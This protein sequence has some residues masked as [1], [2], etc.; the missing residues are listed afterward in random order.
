MGPNDQNPAWSPDG[1]QL[2]FQSDRSGQGDWD[3]YLVRWDGSGLTQLTSGPDT[4]QDPTWSPDGS[5][6][7]FVRNGLIHVMNVD[8]SGVTQLT[9]VGFDT[10]PA[11]SPNGTRI[12]FEHN[13]I[14]VVNADGSGVVQLTT[15]SSRLTD[16]QP[17]WSPDGSRIVFQR[18]LDGW[19]W[20]YFM[21]QDGTGL[22]RVVSGSSPAWSPD[23][24][25]IVYHSWG[26]IVVM[27]DGTGM[28]RLGLTG[29]GY[30]PAWS[31][32]GTMPPEPV[33]FRSVEMAGGDGQTGTVGTTLTL[34]FSVR[35]VGDDGTPQAGARIQWQV[36]WSGTTD[37]AR[38]DALSVENGIT[39]ANGISSARLTLDGPSGLVHVRAA[40][41]DGTTRRGEVVFT[42]TAVP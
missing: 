37:P 35:V 34:P 41:T 14:Q 10:H 27:P 23:S 13:G 11:W 2:M 26:I 22:T 36:D 18:T 29:P 42:A 40:L 25:R 9:D 6:I 3:I 31:L 17:A 28:T 32:V 4:D 21:N 33:P 30:A 1:T 16:Q 38:R 39:D 8:G 15:N 20:V 19:V 24:R 5:K 7:A 12:A